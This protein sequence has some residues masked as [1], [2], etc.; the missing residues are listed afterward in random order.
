MWIAL[1]NE[2]KANPAELYK[3]MNILLFGERG[4]IGSQVRPI[5]VERG[6]NVIHSELNRADSVESVEK[7]LDATKP[8][9]VFSL[10]GRTRGQGQSTIDFLED[11]PRKHNKMVL[12]IRDNLYA[13]LTLALACHARGIHF[14]YMGTGCI[15]TYDG[16]TV[17]FT[18]D[19][20]PNFFG[21]S[22][23]VVK[24]FTDRLMRQLPMTLQARIR[25]PITA[26]QS[27]YSFVT[28]IVGYENIC[29]I[30]NS[31]TVLPTLMPCLV[32][33]IFKG[34]VGTVNLTNPGTISHNR[35][36]TLYRDIV[37]KDFTWKNFDEHEQDKILKSKRSNN[38]LD[39]SRLLEMYPD[40]PDIETAITACLRTIVELRQ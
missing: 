39:T 13:P 35:V 12:N 31:M 22:Y 19:D 9:R 38:A 37:D 10:I 28:K 4:W 36:L 25:M 33:M 29:S 5:L 24:G 16:D 1:K 21:S 26:D 20:D 7:L 32:D 18:E 2:Y 40:V 6:F 11:E 8:D 3:I 30:E 34:I 14:T 15:F 27:P 17:E 23:S